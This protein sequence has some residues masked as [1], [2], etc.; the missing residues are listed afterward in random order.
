MTNRGG[1]YCSSTAIR[2]EIRGFMLNPNVSNQTGSLRSLP[3]RSIPG[4][5]QI[6]QT[7]GNEDAASEVLA[8][9]GNG[10][11]YEDRIALA[12]ASGGKAHENDDV[13]T[14]LIR[15]HATFVY[16]IAYSVLKDSHDAEDVAQE[17][18]IRVMKNVRRLPL[19]RDER[20]WLARI[21]WRLAVTKAAK[22]Q[23]KRK[24]EV[25][26]GEH[27]IAV[28]NLKSGLMADSNELL[29]LMERL[30]ASLPANL[31]HPLVLSAIEETSNRE[32]AEILN[33]SEATVRTRIHRA[34]KLLREKL[35]TIFGKDY[36][37]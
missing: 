35:R 27:F 22:H 15:Q 20:A 13:L 28:S 17:T 8:L 25:D 32:V 3:G 21:T 9:E 4:R 7:N 24:V 23:R 34:R 31:R 18:F 11:T 26:M 12:L 1:A 30:T 16:R 2:T 6:S 37:G 19:I 14:A 10:M 5:S 36:A 29:Q 33:I